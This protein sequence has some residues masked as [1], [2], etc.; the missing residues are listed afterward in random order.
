ME[1]ALAISINDESVRG[2]TGEDASLAALVETH[3]QL[4]YRVALAVTRNKQDAEDA[5]QEAFLQLHRGGRWERIEEPRSYLARVAWRMALRR[6]G[7]HAAEEAPVEEIA[8]PAASPEEAAM[9]RE[10]QVWV[11][12]AIDRLPEKLRQPLVLA[13]LG[14][15]KLVEVARILR[16]P[17][18]TVR[19]RIHSARQRLKQEMDRIERRRP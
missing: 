9:E 16:L 5:V 12:S 13:A 3:G 6:R 15:L 14:E 1:N 2:E 19:R 10:R 18:G 4:A 17:E 8:S 7:S 11:H